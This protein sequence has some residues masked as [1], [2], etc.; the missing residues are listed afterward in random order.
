VLLLSPVTTHTHARARTHTHTHR[1]RRRRHGYRHHHGFWT[2]PLLDSP[3]PPAPPPPPPRP[4]PPPASPPLSAHSAHVCPHTNVH[5][6]APRHALHQWQ[7]LRPFLLRRLKTE[8]ENQLPDKVEHVLK[9][10]MSALQM[11]LCV[12]PHAHNTRTHARTHTHT[13]TH[14]HTYTHIHT[15]HHN[16]TTMTTTAAVILTSK[17]AQHDF[18]PRARSLANLHFNAPTSP[19]T[20]FTPPHLHFT[21]P[22]SL[23]HS[24]PLR[25]P[26]THPPCQK[27]PPHEEARGHFVPARGAPRRRV[28]QGQGAD[29]QRH[30]HEQLHHATQKDLQSPVSVSSSGPRLFS[31]PRVSQVTQ[32]LAQFEPIRFSQILFSF[33]SH[34][35]ELES[36]FAG[37][38]ARR[39]ASWRCFPTEDNAT[40]IHP[41][42]NPPTQ[43]LKPSHPHSPTHSLI[44]LPTD[45]PPT[46]SDTHP[47]YSPP[48]HEHTHSFAHSLIGLPNDTLPTHLDTHTPTPALSPHS[49]PRTERYP[50][51][52]L[53]EDLWRSCGKFE[54]LDRVL[55]KLFRAGHRCLI[56]SQMVELLTVLEDYCNFKRFKYLKL[57]GTTRSEDRGVLIEKFNAVASECVFPSMC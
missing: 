28:G 44:H 51:G 6:A 30:L 16:R 25:D 11:R 47:P 5:P 43:T 7:V 10:R 2:P 42:T 4:P 15:H 39:P 46:H 53:H 49:H 55:P 9:C 13:H 27:V 1:R 56:F 32:I 14:T 36:D 35:L 34:L 18:I 21:S 48:T 45:T 38:T 12:P 26:P 24:S 17:E 31:A 3:P 8:V 23:T 57:D 37:Q 29:W 41:L 19:A 54:L 50:S 52:T 20:W 40:L 22:T 33:F